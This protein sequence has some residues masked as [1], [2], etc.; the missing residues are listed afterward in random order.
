MKTIFSCVITCLFPL[1]GFSQVEPILYSDGPIPGVTVESPAG[2]GNFQPATIWQTGLYRVRNS[3]DKSYWAIRVNQTSASNN[4]YIVAGQG[5]AGV[6]VVHSQND[7]AN[8]PMDSIPVFYISERALSIN[9]AGV[10]ALGGSFASAAT[11]DTIWRIEPG[12]GATIVAQENNPAFQ[13]PN[14]G[15]MFGNIGAP[16]ISNTNRIAFDDASG[17]EQ[18]I[19]WDNGLFL[20]LAAEGSSLNNVAGRVV[21]NVQIGNANAV[22]GGVF[23]FENPGEDPVVSFNGDL[24]GDS[25]S[26]NFF[27]IRNEN[28]GNFEAFA[29]AGLSPDGRPLLSEP[30]G[31]IDGNGN[32]YI[33]PFSPTDM[34]AYLNG[35]LVAEAGGNVGGNVPGENWVADDPVFLHSPVI[36][37]DMNSLGGYIIGGVTD[38]TETFSAVG[39]SGNTTITK[40]Q[41]IVY[42]APDGT[43]TELVRN[44]DEVTVDVDGTSEVRRIVTLGQQDSTIASFVDDTHMYFLAGTEFFAGTIPD[45]LFARIELPGQG[46]LLGDMNCDGLLNLLDVAPFVLALSKPD[47]YEAAFPGCPIEAADIDGNGVINLVDVAPFVEVISGF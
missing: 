47:E 5:L 9:D 3:P 16:T 30:F 33:V 6:T 28:T 43:R 1:I 37:L 32:D 34:F 35:S 7:T 41:V 2:S 11:N 29:G 24:D 14:G 39:S 31:W 36:A 22:Q 17:T 27:A 42:V 23:Y 18:A 19:L 40:N 20:E 44:G 45:D 15:G 13:R 26:D 10:I 8:V 38:N 21:Q 25:S 12:I 4:E 46:F